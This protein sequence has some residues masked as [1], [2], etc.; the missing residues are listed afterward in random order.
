METIRE[1]KKKNLIISG[2]ETWASKFPLAA[3]SKQSPVDIETANVKYHSSA[4][5]LTFN[6]VPKNDCRLCNSGY[7]WKVSV[8]DEKSELSGGPLEGKYKLEQFHC[9]WGCSNDKG[10]EH[11]VNG[12]CFAGELHLVHWNSTKYSSFKEAANYSDGLAVLGIFLK[13]TCS[14]NEE[15]EK[16]VTKIPSVLFRN[17]SVQIENYINP[18]N[19]LPEKKTYWTYQGSLTT[20]PC[21][22]NV[23]WIIFKDP[24]EISDRQ[25]SIFRTL[26][27][28]TKE[29]IINE[30]D[31]LIMNNYRPPLPLGNRELRE[32]GSF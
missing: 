16:V 18:F 24:V 23:T 1:K 11:T 14:D 12:Q 2:P 20:P 3:G 19:L 31:G 7:G 27:C 4:A 30:S 5:S 22:E 17:E 9:H 21:T 28:H 15:L 6:Y 29:N 10:S 8:E 32:C 25:L 13:V 26:R